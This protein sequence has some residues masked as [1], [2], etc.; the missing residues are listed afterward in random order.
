M[1]AEKRRSSVSQESGLD[2]TII[3]PGG[4]LRMK[5]EGGRAYPRPE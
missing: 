3:R 2:Y 5:G 4:L 1:A